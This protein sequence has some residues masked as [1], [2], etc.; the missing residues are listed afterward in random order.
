[1]PCYRPK[2]AAVLL[3]NKK[4]RPEMTVTQL[5]CGKCLGCIARRRQEWTIRMVHE[6]QMRDEAVFLTLTYDQ[7]HL[8]ADGSL[9]RPGKGIM[10]DFTSQLRN[11][12]GP[13]RY[14][15]VGEYGSENLRPHYHA[16]LFFD[17]SSNGKRTAFPDRYEWM[18]RHGEPVF[19]SD[20]LE[21]CWPHGYSTIQP[22][23]EAS[24]RYVAGYTTKKLGDL[25]DPHGKRYERLDPI[26]GEVWEVLP[27][28]QTMSRRPGLGSDWFD[29]YWEDV[30][31]S[32]E[33]IVDGRRYRPPGYYDR[34]LEKLHPDLHREVRINRADWKPENSYC[35]T[36]QA[37]HAA[38]AKH[39]AREKR[40]TR[41]L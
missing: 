5:P 34:R 11:K 15:L 28:W 41:E 38:E 13:F 35:R 37:R 12:L 36:T 1:M 30:Y 16:I 24:I 31:P 25:E 2:P 40:I 21:H 19:R 33:V 8:P 7:D 26:T 22:V 17:D 23:N 9:A 27:E 14:F 20:V 39:R 32:D 10:S 6:A 29:A 4:T 18:Q 3:A